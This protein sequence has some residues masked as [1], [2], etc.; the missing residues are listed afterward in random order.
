MHPGQSDLPGNVWWAAAPK[1]R[2][3]AGLP[4]IVAGCADAVNTPVDEYGWQLFAAGGWNSD[5]D[6][7]WRAVGDY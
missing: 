1:T 6:R 5:F 2:M 4:L 7:A 3:A